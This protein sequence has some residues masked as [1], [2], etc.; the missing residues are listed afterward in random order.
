M[1]RY[2]K[3]RSLAFLGLRVLSWGDQKQGRHA[4]NDASI[5]CSNGCVGCGVVVLVA[6]MVMVVL[7]VMMAVMIVVVMIV[8]VMMVV[9][10]I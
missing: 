3:S 9:V 2:V 4:T 6:L 10:M 7:V 8:V 5:M 1:L